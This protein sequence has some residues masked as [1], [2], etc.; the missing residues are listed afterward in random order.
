MKKKLYFCRDAQGDDEGFAYIGTSLKQTK[1]LFYKTDFPGHSYFDV[2]I[3]EIKLS[4]PAVI[5]ELPLG[6]LDNSKFAL[7]IGAYSFGEY[8]CE[9]CGEAHEMTRDNFL[10]KELL[11]WRCLE[12]EN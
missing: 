9:K 4:D 7:K 5:Q 6:Y 10:G 11:C 8:T 12:R 1:A 2:R 3:R